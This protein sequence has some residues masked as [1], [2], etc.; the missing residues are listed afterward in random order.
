MLKLELAEVVGVADK[1]SFK[2][3]Y[4]VLAS[5]KHDAEV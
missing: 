5:I 2:L 3:T 1:Y 4:N